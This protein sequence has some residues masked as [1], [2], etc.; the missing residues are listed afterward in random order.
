MTISRS[1]RRLLAVITALVLA[2]LYAPLALVVVNSFN[3]S[4]AL[5]WPPSWAAACHGQRGS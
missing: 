2:M 4:Q 3:T 1:T 5:T